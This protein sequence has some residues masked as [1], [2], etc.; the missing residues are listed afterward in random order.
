MN[1][2]EEGLEEYENEKSGYDSMSIDEITRGGFMSALQ[3]EALESD[4]VLT[5]N[6]AIGYASAGSALVDLNFAISSLCRSKSAVNKEERLAEI[7]KKFGLAYNENKELAVRLLFNIGDMRQGHG[8]RDLFNDC[9]EY[10]CKNQPEMAKALIKFIPEYARWDMVA[11]L[12]AHKNNVIANEAGKVIKEQ[13]EED[14]KA[15]KENRDFD[16]SLMAKW[17]PKENTQLAGAICFKLG[18]EFV[19]EENGKLKPNRSAYRKQI[20]APLRE[21][22]NVIERNIAAQTYGKIDYNK[23]P[24]KAHHKYVN[25][26]L[27]YDKERY[28]KYIE[29]VIEGKGNINA[30]VL[31]PYEIIM[32][33]TPQKNP[34]N[35]DLTAEAM[36]AKKVK[37]LK[38][39][40]GEN[41]GKI[42]MVRDGSGSMTWTQI[43]GCKA[44][45]LDIATALTLLTAETLE[46]EWKNKFI[47]FSSHPEIVDVSNAK[48]LKDKLDICKRH[49]DCSNTD[50]KKTFE[51]ILNTAVKGNY[52]EKD[53]PESIV[54]I[55]DMEFDAGNLRCPLFKEIEQQWKEKGYNLPKLVFWNVCS[56]ELAIPM[57]ENENGVVLMSG[58]NEKSFDMVLNNELDV[59][60]LNEILKAA[61]IKEMSVETKDGKMDISK[62]TPEQALF[63]K[64]IS[65]RYDEVGLEAREIIEKEQKMKEKLEKQKEPKARTSKERTSKKLTSAYE[66]R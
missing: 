56:K 60:K 38:E 1:I 5:E 41:A 32:N 34:L 52:D 18:G 6:G 27:K 25:L 11:N 22:L 8:E 4:T 7:D 30:G 23:I 61:G 36:W 42:L 2:F 59:D 55:S 64:L 46:G 21:K 16:I 62:P 63:A 44:Y 48:F 65:E 15:M 13:L 57:R 10:I 47:T 45:P 28:T 51:L 24:A 20:I 58:F 35:L 49:T 39:S 3:E 43:K 50:I 14:L 29:G 53:M 54:I 26:F 33:Y 31:A 40:L 19:V 66:D 37:E 17:L 12:V 9:F